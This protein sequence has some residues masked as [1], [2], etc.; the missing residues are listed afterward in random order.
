M[1]NNFRVNIYIFF[2]FCKL[3]VDYFL[4]LRQNLHDNILLA[5]SMLLKKE[6]R[7]ATKKYNSIH[8]DILYYIKAGI[9]SSSLYLKP[10]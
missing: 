9:H 2:Q 7:K 1:P 3:R 4:V 5:T 6:I 8:M 10:S